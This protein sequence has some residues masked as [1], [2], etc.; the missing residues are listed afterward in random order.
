MRDVRKPVKRP[1]V[2]VSGLGQMADADLIDMSTY[3]SANNG[4]VFILLVIDVFSKYVWCQ[5]LKN[6]SNKSVVDAFKT[7][8]D[9]SPK[10]WYLRTDLGKEFAGSY[11]QHFLK[12]QGIKHFASHNDHHAN[13]AERCIKSLKSRLTRYLIYKQTEQWVDVLQPMVYSYN[14]SYHRTIKMSPSEVNHSNEGKILA[15]IL[16]PSTK[17]PQASA[18]R[19][20]KL[21]RIGKA[22]K[23]KIGD[24]VRISHLKSIFDR[25]YSQKWS[26]EIFSVTKRQRREN[27]PVYS[28]SDYHGQPIVGKFYE[29]ELQKVQFDPNQKWK[30]EKILKSRTKHGKK[31]HFVKYLHWPSRFNDWVS[32]REVQ[33]T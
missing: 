6:K 1:R 30:I 23:L 28:L 9:T 13:I 17:L 15:N 25:Q 19:K 32:A 10:F 5:P 29:N 18:K 26:G 2:R 21:K 27:I 14:H 16:F 4:Y 12:Q 3:K 7:V 20:R 31:E 33:N 8:F 24:H 11:T 22:Y